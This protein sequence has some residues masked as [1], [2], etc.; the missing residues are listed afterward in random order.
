M[1]EESKYLTSSDLM[2]KI[3]WSIAAL[4]PLVSAL[5]YLASHINET[6]TNIEA[7]QEEIA[8]AKDLNKTLLERVTALQFDLLREQGRGEGR[9]GDIQELSRKVT[10]MNVI[11]TDTNRSL[12]RLLGKLERD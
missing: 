2:Q 5:W 4:I 9:H 7:I 6:N 3:R 1:T 10:E 8:T 12:D 11:L